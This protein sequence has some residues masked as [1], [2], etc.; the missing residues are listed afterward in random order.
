MSI[1]NKNPQDCQDKSTPTSH[2]TSSAQ[3]RRHTGSPTLQPNIPKEFHTEQ[4]Q[5]IELRNSLTE[6]LTHT[7]NMEGEVK[8]T[9]YYEQQLKIN[10]ELVDR[11]MKVLCTAAAT[12]TQTMTEMQET[13][14]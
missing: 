12:Q 13:Q 11:D 3:N 9:A 14:R 5:I 4:N 2:R 6:A 10:M 7:N 1:V 8:K